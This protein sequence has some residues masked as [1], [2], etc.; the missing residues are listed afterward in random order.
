MNFN[1]KLWPK[2]KVIAKRFTSIE[3]QN[4]QLLLFQLRQQLISGQP[5]FFFLL[6][7]LQEGEMCFTCGDD[8]HV[9]GGGG[10]GG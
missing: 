1:Q 6:P 9:L 4:H 8:Y 7:N 5:T 3:S 2:T 10:S